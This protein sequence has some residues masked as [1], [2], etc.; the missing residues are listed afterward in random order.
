ML[1]HISTASLVWDF[2]AVTLSIIA[3]LLH[4]AQQ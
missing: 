3:K 2:D 1:S 4:S